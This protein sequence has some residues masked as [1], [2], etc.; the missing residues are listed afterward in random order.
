MHLVLRLRLGGK[1]ASVVAYQ[2]TH[3]HALVMELNFQEDR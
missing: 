3:Q 1:R 2:A